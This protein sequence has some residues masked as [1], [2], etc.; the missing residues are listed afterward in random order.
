MVQRYS[1]ATILVGRDNLRREG[2]A[3]VLRSANI[4]ILASLSCAGGLLTHK[5]QSCRLMFLIVCGDDDF[6][7]TTEQVEVFKTRFP[8]ARIAVVAD[9]YRLSEL[10]A[11][12]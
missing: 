5:V 8:D 3:R 2:I 7:A 4:R 1:F 10:V 9:H 6:D 11:A 12:F